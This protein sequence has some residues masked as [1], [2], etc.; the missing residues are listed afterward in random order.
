M[1]AWTTVEVMAGRALDS[2][3]GQ[4]LQVQWAASWPRMAWEG[5]EEDVGFGAP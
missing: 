5:G 2:L 4:V 1:G 3:G